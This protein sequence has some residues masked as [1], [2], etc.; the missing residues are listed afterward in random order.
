MN[1]REALR[2]LSFAGGASLLASRHHSP[3]FSGPNSMRLRSSSGRH[4]TG[5]D[6]RHQ[7]DPDGA[8]SYS[9]GRRESRNNGGAFAFV[10]VGAN[11]ARSRGCFLGCF[12]DR[13]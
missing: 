11:A 8:E 12:S 5:E 9:A 2:S 7:N 6:P 1:R 3:K 10:K 13:G 4:R